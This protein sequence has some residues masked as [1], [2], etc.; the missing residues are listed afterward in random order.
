MTYLLFGKYTFGWLMTL[1][2]RLKD[3]NAATRMV[4]GDWE[5]RWGRRIS[6]V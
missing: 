1:A 4:F 6:V 2:L 5:L 3:F